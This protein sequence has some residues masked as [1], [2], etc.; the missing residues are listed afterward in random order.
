MG[1]PP[2]VTGLHV[3]E[4]VLYAPDLASVRPF[5]ATVLGLT[6]IS[7]NLP[8]GLAFR[9][10]DRSILLIF[11]PALTRLHHDLVPSHGCDGGGHVAFRIERGTLEEWTIKLIAAGY[12]IEREV[13][14]PTGARSIYVRDP[15]GNSVELV[16]GEIWPR[17]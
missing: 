15:A 9:V 1:T 7:R 8:R 14:W 16:E 5:Y 17:G 10:D 12:P 11:N 2:S 3:Y 6:D 13:D 4:T